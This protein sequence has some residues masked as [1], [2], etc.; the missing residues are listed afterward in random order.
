MDVLSL[1]T[2]QAVAQQ[3]GITGAAQ[4][5]H[6]VQSNITQRIRTLESELGLALFNR[7]SRGM[8]LTRAGQRLLPYV[9][10]IAA[11]MDEA[12]AAAKG[13]QDTPAP[14]VIGSME[15]TAAV[16][17]PSLLASFRRLYPQVAIS[18]ETGPT[19]TLIDAVLQRR[20]DGAF[21]AGPLDNHSLLSQVAFE[22]ELVLVSSVNWERA[23]EIGKRLG[24]GAAAIMFKTGCSYRQRFEQLLSERGW[25]RFT[26]LEMGTLEGILGCVAAEVGISLLP[27]SV[28][29]N[30]TNRDALR[31]HPSKG[32]RS[33]V[34][35]LFI[36]RKDEHPG[37]ALHHFMALL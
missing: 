21:I 26:R 31:C 35:T 18:L 17:L 9:H 37:T 23:S 25:P 8:E 4:V 19:A 1:R 34:Q 30:A 27:R 33:N 12:Q 3:G 2:F 28:V 22:E 6:T 29:D 11:L 7:H 13:E 24:N 32:K 16:R 36:R 5:L 15:T 14:L 20:V 10:R